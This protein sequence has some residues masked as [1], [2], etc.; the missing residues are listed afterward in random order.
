MM[1]RVTRRQDG[2]AAHGQSSNWRHRSRVLDVAVRRHLALI[3]APP[4]LAL[5]V[6]KTV[7]DT[8]GRYGVCAG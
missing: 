6:L 5:E 3:M 1:I 7:A 4:A 2:A 8:L